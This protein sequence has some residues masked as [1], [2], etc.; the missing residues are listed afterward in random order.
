M[1][2]IFI[3]FKCYSI[4]SFDTTI[5]KLQNTFKPK[6]ISKMFSMIMV[7]LRYL[8]MYINSYNC[9]FTSRSSI[10]SSCLKSTLNLLTTVVAAISLHCLLSSQIICCCT[11]L[12]TNC[13]II[14][15]RLSRI[16]E[17]ISDI[18]NIE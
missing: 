16:L 17:D 6:K 9:H 8:P 1:F 15:F 13:N 5:F 10:G 11:L 18:I 7:N 2:S 14:F 12:L 4:T 3:F